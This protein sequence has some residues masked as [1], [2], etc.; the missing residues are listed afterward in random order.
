MEKTADRVLCE[1]ASRVFNKNATESRAKRDKAF[2]YDSLESYL[3]ALESIGMTSDRYTVILFR[4]V[5]SCKPGFL[6]SVWLR[7]TG[8]LLRDDNGNSIFGDRIKDR[9]SFLLSEVEGEE[10][11]SSVKY[12]SRL[13]G[14][15]ARK[16]NRKEKVKETAA[17]ATDLLSREK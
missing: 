15:V 8:A 5:E 14:V 11:S 17:M 10:R 3:L 16:E 12:G 13:S 6:L 7:N 9:L 4:F 2:V 1:E